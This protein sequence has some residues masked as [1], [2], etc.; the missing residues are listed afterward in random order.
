MIAVRPVA[1]DD[2]ADALFGRI[3]A[4]C[5]MPGGFY[6]DEVLA[7]GSRLVEVV[8]DGERVGA[9]IVRT[10]PEDAVIVAAAGAAPGVDLVRAVLPVVEREAFAAGFQGVRFHTGRAGLIRKA[11][12]MGWRRQET[13]MRKDRG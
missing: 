1:W 3:A 6:R 5:P 11:E 10:E 9:F 13:V 4:T 7:R 12:A 8:S 2:G